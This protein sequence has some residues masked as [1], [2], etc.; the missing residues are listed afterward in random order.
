MPYAKIGKHDRK[1]GKRI[2]GKDEA[3]IYA[4]ITDPVKYGNQKLKEICVANRRGLLAGCICRINLSVIGNL[5]KT[6]EAGSPIDPS[7][8]VPEKENATKE[9][10][11]IVMELLNSV[12][13]PVERYSM[14]K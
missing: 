10:S 8:D 11:V 2:E 1:R 9:R 12:G 7:N 6:D 3:V 13:M 4:P 5:L 14:N